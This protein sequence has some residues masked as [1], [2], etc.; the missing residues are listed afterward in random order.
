MELEKMELK[1]CI[2]AEK[3]LISDA[4]EKIGYIVSGSLQVSDFCDEVSITLSI[5]KAVF[6]EEEK[7][8]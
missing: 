7:L 6:E 5:R 8:C 3:K 4:L 1:D 2:K